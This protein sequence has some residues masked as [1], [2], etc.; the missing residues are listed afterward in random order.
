LAKKE[1]LELGKK[2]ME[3]A[4]TLLSKVQKC[5]FCQNLFLSVSSTTFPLHFVLVSQVL[6]FVSPFG[7]FLRK[8]DTGISNLSSEYE[9]FLTVFPQAKNLEK[10]KKESNLVQVKISQVRNT[11]LFPPDTPKEKAYK[12]WSENK[13]HPYQE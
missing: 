6:K 7:W 10:E 12:M 8:K 2:S 3:I 11:W 13:S 4:G 9:S 5:I 1:S